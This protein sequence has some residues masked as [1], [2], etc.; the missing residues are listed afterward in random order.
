[1]AFALL[2]IT[3]WEKKFL[4]N[5]IEGKGGVVGNP[6]KRTQ[7]L[8]YNPYRAKDMKFWST[9]LERE[10]EDTIYLLTP[11]LFY[12]WTDPEY[13]F[14][15]Q[16]FDKQL[17]IARHYLNHSDD[18]KMDQHGRIEAIEK[19]LLSEAGKIIDALAKENTEE[20]A[21]DLALYFNWGHQLVNGKWFG[22][23]K[24]DK[25]T[26]AGALSLVRDYLMEKGA[27][28]AAKQKTLDEVEAYMIGA[29]NRILKKFY[30]EKDTEV[31]SAFLNYLLGKEEAWKESG[32]SDGFYVYNLVKNY[33]DQAIETGDPELISW[34]LDYKASHFD[35]FFV[36]EADFKELD[37]EFGLENK[38]AVYYS[39]GSTLTFGKFVQSAEDNAE[40]EPIEW[41]VL[42]EENG[43]A[44]IISKY[45]LIAIPYNYELEPVTWENCT[46]RKWLNN[47]FYED[48]F[49]GEEKTNIL[50][51]TNTNPDNKE[52]KTNGGNDTEDKIFLLSL[53]EAKVLF[54]DDESRIRKATAFAKKS[55]TDVNV[56]IGDN[57]RWWLRSPGGESDFAASVGYRH[58]LDDVGYYVN[59]GDNAV[60]PA[61][62]I[63]LNA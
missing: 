53:D 46:L 29:R 34:I 58:G 60:C 47:E 52:Y 18:W 36:E 57:C 32:Y 42:K 37:Y 43:K 33:T 59:R 15:K 24:P 51:V 5:I 41:E 27:W 3:G 30:S 49:S 35:E 20:A 25:M 48:C 39:K 7:Y 1:M 23:A 44:L 13:L 14:E 40:A 19:M 55:G 12:L 38:P 22:K 21:D 26:A 16:K 56:F 10:A 4:T 45:G 6:G 61:F 63:N 50:E 9:A 31:F 54:A 11:E 8:I 62:W 2:G 17:N 28:K